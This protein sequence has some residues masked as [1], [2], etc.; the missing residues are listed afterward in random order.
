MRFLFCLLFIS[1]Q[2]FS[3]QRKLV[4]VDAVSLDPVPYASL[5][6]TR[7]NVGFYT[8]SDGT[9]EINNE[10]KNQETLLISC[11]GYKSAIIDLNNFVKDTIFLTPQIEYLKEVT[12]MPQ[13]AKTRFVGYGKKTKK[14]SWPLRRG[15]QIGA[16]MR[17]S[18]YERGN[19]VKIKA[20]QIPVNKR[21]RFYEGKDNLNNQNINTIIKVNL[22][23]INDNKPSETMLE[24][25]IIINFNQNSSDVISIDLT[26]KNIFFSKD[27]IYL[28]IEMVG[29]PTY[30]KSIQKADKL[31]LLP[32][33]GITNKPNKD[34]ISVTYQKSIFTENWEIFDFEKLSLNSVGIKNI[35][36]KVVI[37]MQ[38]ETINE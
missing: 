14:I 37:G 25:P 29:D 17:L 32:R 4:L 36:F 8:D 5:F 13:N 23:T 33:I 10:N 20:I 21:D 22:Y 28:A 12:V 24:K 1:I 38:I 6:Y 9:F 34:I 15:N 7:L 3:Q 30:L 26:G 27:G 2:S 18:G 31:F 35:D 11:M 16:L 19:H